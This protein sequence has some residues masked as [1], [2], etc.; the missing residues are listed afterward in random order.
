MLKRLIVGA[1]VAGVAVLVVQSIPDI[2]R[3]LRIRKM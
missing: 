2:K 1:L 3:Y